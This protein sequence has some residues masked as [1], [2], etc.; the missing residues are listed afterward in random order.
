MFFRVTLVRFVL[1]SFSLRVRSFHSRTAF[2]DLVSSRKIC[3]TEAARGSRCCVRVPGVC[4]WR[5]R[6]GRFSGAVSGPGFWGG[7]AFWLEMIFRGTALQAR[8]SRTPVARAREN[9][10]G[11]RPC[12]WPNQSERCTCRYDTALTR[13]EWSALPWRAKRRPRYRTPRTTIAACRKRSPTTR[14]VTGSSPKA[15]IRFPIPVRVALFSCYCT[16]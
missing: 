8:W 11:R 5:R 16:G 3:V 13:L 14:Q 1:M 15:R 9:G 7:R 2:V 4:A 6:C 12:T 10:G